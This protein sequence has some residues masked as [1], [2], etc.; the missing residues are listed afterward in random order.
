LSAFLPRVRGIVAN[1]AKGRFS[2][3]RQ[4]HAARILA[5]AGPMSLFELLDV[6][7]GEK[8]ALERSLESLGEQ[9][10]VQVV[11]TGHAPAP[12]QPSRLWSLTAE[13]RAALPLEPAADIGRFKEGWLWIHATFAADQAIDID[14]ALLDG[15][16]AAAAAW[17]ARLDGDGRG[18]MF[19]FDPQIG[20]QPAE[21]L[22]R[23]LSSV[24]A[25]C[26]TGSSREPQSAQEFVQTLRTASRAALRAG[27]RHARREESQL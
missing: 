10:L 8:R 5:S 25:R 17:V 27:E 4:K 21:N 2:G 22:F 7:G 15:E 13:G 24:G 6:V 20:A 3:A 14:D 23:A 12:G 16:L 11:A 26:S 18:Y 19:V 1:V 9:G